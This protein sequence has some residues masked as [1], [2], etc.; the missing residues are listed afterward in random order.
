[1]QKKTQ[2][3]P[4]LDAPLDPDPRTDYVVMGFYN[5]TLQASAVGLG[6]YSD[7]AETIIKWMRHA[8]PSQTFRT[9]VQSLRE[10]KYD[11]VLN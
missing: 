2:K 10:K 1:M 3:K 5:A 6:K 9:I 7:D 8:I 4:K 11:S